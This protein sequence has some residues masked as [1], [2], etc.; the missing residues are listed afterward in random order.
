MAYKQSSWAKMKIKYN[1]LKYSIKI[2][3]TW[4]MLHENQ[5]KTQMYNIRFKQKLVA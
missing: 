1:K 5:N 3:S 2:K 4:K